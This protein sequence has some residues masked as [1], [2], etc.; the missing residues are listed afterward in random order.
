[1]K[2]KKSKGRHP[3]DV[4]EV[5]PTDDP[6]AALNTLMDRLSIWSALA[7]MSLEPPVKGKE[8]DDGGW[9]GTLKRFW[10]EIIVPS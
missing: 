9:A 2:R 5:S 8:K 10:E 7:D 1:M 3:D 4:M 6:K